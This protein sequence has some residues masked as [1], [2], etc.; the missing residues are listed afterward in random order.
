MSQILVPSRAVAVEV[1]EQRD[2]IAWAIE[3]RVQAARGEC[4]GAVG[5]E[6]FCQFLDVDI[7]VGRTDGEESYGAAFVML[8]PGICVQNRYLSTLPSHRAASDEKSCACPVEMD[9][10]AGDW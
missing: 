9:F 6:N 10:Y 1:E 8:A 7:S 2:F 3:E 4:H 5:P